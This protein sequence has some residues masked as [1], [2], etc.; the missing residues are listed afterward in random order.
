MEEQKEG[1]KAL[2]GI[3]MPQEQ[4]QL[5]WIFGLSESE[6][7]AKEHTQAGPRPPHS[8]VADVQLDCHVSPKQLE[9]GAIP[10]AIA[11]LWDMFY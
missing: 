5:T 2:K 3:G 1:F 4:S 9:Q 10:K 7:P 11:C 8:Y 6:P